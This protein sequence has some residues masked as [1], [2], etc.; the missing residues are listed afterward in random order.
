MRRLF[1]ALLA[2]GIACSSAPG[3]DQAVCLPESTLDPGDTLPDCAFEG[4]GDQPTLRL[5]DLRGKPSVLNFWASWCVSC[6]REMPDFQ[7]VFADLGGEVTFVGMNTL[8]VQGETRSA[9]ERFGDSTGVR[10]PLAYDEDGLLYAHFGISAD[11]P[12][13]PL[14]VM[15]D[16]ELRVRHV[17]FGELREQTI[18]QLI[19]EHLGVG[20]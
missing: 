8:G 15:V 1:P 16:E 6:I 5:A 18:R 11:R 10:Y 4:V 13:M 14:T 7:E 12:I 17:N 20:S 19:Q 3:V 9:A 2:V